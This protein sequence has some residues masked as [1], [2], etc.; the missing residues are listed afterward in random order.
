MPGVVQVNPGGATITFV[1]VETITLQCATC[2]VALN[3]AVPMAAVAAA[4]VK[5]PTTK[6]T[7]E[8]ESEPMDVGHFSSST[9][10]RIGFPEFFEQL[11]RNSERRERNNI[12]A[13]DEAFAD[14]EEVDLDDEELLLA[15]GF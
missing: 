13:T 9:G 4:L 6:N 15:V 1:D 14:L 7:L 12:I 5:Q 3:E 2:A 11:A 8:E 10:L